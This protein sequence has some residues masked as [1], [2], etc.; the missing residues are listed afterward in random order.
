MLVKY[1]I[2]NVDIRLNL[3]D[4]LMTSHEDLSI[5][6]IESTLVVGDSWH[7]LDD[8]GVIWVLAL[9]VENV[10]G[11]NHII[12]NV[13]LGDLLGAE[14]ALRA[15]VLAIVVTEMVVRSDRGQLDTSVDQEINKGRLHLGLARLEVV[16]TDE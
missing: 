10:V 14:L 12:D 6:L 16:T 11:L 3:R 2:N 7:V 15:Q 13:G 9:L 8:D 1:K 4:S 5:V